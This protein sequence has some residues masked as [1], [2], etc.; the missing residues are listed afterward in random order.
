MCYILM[1][2]SFCATLVSRLSFLWHIIWLAWIFF[3]EL[4]EVVTCGQ[5]GV[6]YFNGIV[7]LCSIS[8]KASL[9]VAYYLAGVDILL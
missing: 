5:V 3:Y 6:L 9:L 1:V 4:G 8:I 2:L 7:I